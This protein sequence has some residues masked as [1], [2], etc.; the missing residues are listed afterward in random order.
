MLELIN[1]LSLPANLLAR[2]GGALP[3]DTHPNHPNNSHINNHGELKS[4]NF[5]GKKGKKMK[6][7]GRIE[8][9]RSEGS[10]NAGGNMFYYR[11]ARETKASHNVKQDHYKQVTAL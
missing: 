10:E 2:T 6:F 7:K 9:V 1:P 5:G 4:G 11:V 3:S 8:R